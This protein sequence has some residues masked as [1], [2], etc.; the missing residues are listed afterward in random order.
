[1][2][3]TVSAEEALKVVKSND[4]EYLQAAAAVPSVLVKALAR[5]T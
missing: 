1:M 2:Y 5:Q 4:K 3:R